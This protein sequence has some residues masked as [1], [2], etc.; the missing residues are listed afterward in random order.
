MFFCLSQL[1]I[2]LQL[3][4]SYTNSYNIEFWSVLLKFIVHI[5]FYLKKRGEII[6]VL[7]VHLHV[8]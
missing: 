5:S 6:D 1:G 4:D 2:T 7:L 8:F 3:K